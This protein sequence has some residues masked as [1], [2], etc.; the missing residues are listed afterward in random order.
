MPAAPNVSWV[1]GGGH[2]DLDWFK[3][4][5]RTVKLNFHISHLRAVIPYA[6]QTTAI[7]LPVSGKGG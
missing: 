7:E 1:A 5:M 2:L 6:L 3:L 4:V